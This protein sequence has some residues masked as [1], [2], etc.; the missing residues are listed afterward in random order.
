LLCPDFVGVLADVCANPLDDLGQEITDS[1]RILLT[2]RRYLNF[3]L[4]EIFCGLSIVLCYSCKVLHVCFIFEEGL[5]S[6]FCW[7]SMLINSKE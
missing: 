6:V 4:I 7:E 1:V 2:D 3:M 5:V